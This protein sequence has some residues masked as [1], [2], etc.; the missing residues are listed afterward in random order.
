M[1]KYMQRSATLLQSFQT[2]LTS[3]LLLHAV[4]PS[5][6]FFERQEPSGSL[7]ERDCRVVKFTA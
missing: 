3:L 6:A 5:A 4:L 2:T 7:V 1:C